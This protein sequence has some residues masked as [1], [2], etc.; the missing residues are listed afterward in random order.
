[1]LEVD[2]LIVLLLGVP[3]K[4]LALA[5]RL[6]GITRL[7]KLV[8]LIENETSLAKLLADDSNFT[9]YNFGPFSAEIYRCID[10]LVAFE[11]ISDTGK[12]TSNTID[13]WEYTNAVGDEWFDPYATRDFSLTERGKQYYQAL[14][15]ELDELGPYI[16]ELSE[17]KDR[18]APLPLR[19]LIRYVYMNYPTMTSRSMIRDEIIGN[20]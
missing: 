14:A 10:H 13:S 9:A 6:E 7:E 8:F 20:D 19:Q 18:F 16:R 15:S 4:N 12:I 3:T 11:L 17:F 5:D 2:D 1:M